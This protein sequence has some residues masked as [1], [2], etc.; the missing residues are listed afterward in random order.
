VGVLAAVTRAVDLPVL[1]IGGITVDK[2]GE[3][4]GAGAAGVA[5]IGLFAEPDRLGR[6]DNFRRIVGEIH[7]SHTESHVQPR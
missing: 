4:F 1:A 3:V 6:F 7:R 5:A 2:T